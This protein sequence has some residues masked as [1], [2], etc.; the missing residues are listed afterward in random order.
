MIRYLYANELT[1]YPRL[2]ATM[3]R[4]RAI[5]FHDRQGWDVTVDENGEERDQYDALN[6]LY[7]IWERPDGTHG[8]S[9]RFL[10]TTSRCM[11]N[12]HFTDLLGGGTVESPEIWE[13]TRFCLAPGAEPR[14][15]AAL[16]LA[17]GEIMTGFG[18]KHFVG[19]FD[20]RMVRIYRLIGAAPE[21]LG[22]SG[23]G[24]SA[25]SVGL[26]HFSERLQMQ[27]ALSAKLSPDLARSWFDRAF[28]VRF[29]RA[30]EAA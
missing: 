29:K 11:V 25:I 4:D 9:M 7:V 12:E 28:G 5:Q 1:D 21:V 19:V 30:V 26:W 18:I 6:P 23:T 3:F 13:C 10:P 14:V 27:V 17:G 22:T 24:K 16:M 15:S 2:A 8:G 20:A